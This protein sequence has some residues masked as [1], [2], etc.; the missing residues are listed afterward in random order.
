MRHTQ[1]ISAAVSQPSYLPQQLSSLSR[2]FV[3]SSAFD[4]AKSSKDLISENINE[5]D[6][7]EE[8]VRLHNIFC[9]C[10]NHITV[11]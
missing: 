6:A 5:E 7:V 1:S 2:M 9:H 10:V 8:L 4:E 11:E 3:S